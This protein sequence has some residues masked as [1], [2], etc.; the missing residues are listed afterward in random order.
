MSTTRKLDSDSK[1][2]LSAYRVL[3]KALRDKSSKEE[4]LMVRKALEVAM[5]A[6]GGV[7]RKS[8]EPYITHPLEVARIVVQEVG[9]GSLSAAAALLHDVVEDSDYT[10]ED[11]DRLFGEKVARIIDGLTKISGV[12]DPNSSA[13]AENFRKM[14]LTLGDDIRVILIKLADRLHNMRT[15]ESMPA[16]KQ[17]K[18]ASETL[19]IYAPLAHRLGLYNLKTEME[20]LS[21]KYTEPEVYRDISIKMKAIKADELRY[22]KRFS[23]PIKTA[24]KTEGLHFDIKERT[25]SIY[26]I[27]RKMVN[28]G[29][30]FDE[31]YD[32]FA[33]RIILD[34]P[35]EQEKAACW[36]AYSVVTDF[37]RPNP[38]R[39]RD[40]I[41]SPKSN[42]YESLHITVMGPDGHWVEVQIRSARMDVNAE[43]GLA[44]HWKY[45]EEEV[46]DNRLDGW[47][48]KVREALEN[49]DINAL[50]FVD[51]FKFNLFSDDIFVFTPKGELR[52][53]PKGS[54]PLDFS[55]D[56]HTDVGINTLGAKVNGKLVPLNYKLKSGDQVEILTSSKQKPREEWLNYVVTSK[57]RT[58]I[59]SS[60]REERNLVADRG[61]E[62]LARKLGFLRVK[63]NDQIEREL[64][65]FL[66]LRDSQELFYQAGLGLLDNQDLKQFAKDRSGGFYK[67]FRSRLRRPTSVPKE[68]LQPAGPKEHSHLVF[69]NEEQELEYKLAPCCNPIEGDDVFG[70]I[71][72]NEGIKVHRKDCPNAIAMQSRFASRVI[73]AKWVSNEVQEFVAVI[74]IN[75]IDTVGLV[76]K[77]TQIISND[78]N[79]NIRSLN[80]SGDGGVFEGAITVVVRNKMHLQNVMA[81]I[82]KV[83]GIR[84]VDRHFKK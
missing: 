54:S 23:S 50:E 2:I 21:L 19:F 76:N 37:Y 57:A 83:E 17:V 78:L 31:V 27:R 51:D 11:I 24:L 41:S 67:Y 47:L 14:L 66:K 61:K 32:K 22:L 12:F 80:I 36:K 74:N 62:V 6:H 20:D 82:K 15:M 42:G 3:L 75:G 40:W 73:K 38:D 56:I 58:K 52:T 30:T 13:Q 44:S 39:L 18:I 34:V 68:E 45:K 7:R 81:E 71:T 65:H 46:A 84:E 25:K 5:D 10:L 53:L 72:S 55:F 8:G 49:P 29:V 77:I 43:M 16:H 60:L 35:L 59:R 48:K 9:L 79:V 28:Q 64:T 70:F 33:I 4:L 1:I 63:L 69:G 26:S